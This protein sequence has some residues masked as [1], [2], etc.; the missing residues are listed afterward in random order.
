M[1]Y[2]LSEGDI[3]Y[4][5]KCFRRI[6][7]LKYLDCKCGGLIEVSDHTQYLTKKRI[8]NIDEITK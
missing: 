2:R 6:E 1:K 5:G 8:K 4:C 3:G 7:N